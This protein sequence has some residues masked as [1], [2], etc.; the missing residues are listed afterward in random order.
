MLC[1]VIMLIV[2]IE[3]IQKQD[4]HR[5]A[6]FKVC[7]WFS[8]VIKV[9]QSSVGQSANLSA[10]H[11]FV[12]TSPDWMMASPELGPSWHGQEV[13]DK[14]NRNHTTSYTHK[15]PVMIRMTNHCHDLPCQWLIMTILWFLVYRGDLITSFGFWCDSA[16]WFFLGFFS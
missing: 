10:L 3:Q 4:T 13:K 16:T 1:T 2:H 12:Q 7:P 11:C 15:D 14:V 8:K 6:M 5:I 9:I